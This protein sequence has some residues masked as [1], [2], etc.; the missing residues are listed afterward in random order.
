MLFEVLESFNNKNFS[1][2][3][4]SI[5]LKGASKSTQKSNKISHKAALFTVYLS[6]FVLILLI[7][8]LVIDTKTLSIISSL[9][10][11]QSQILAPAR[12]EKKS[13]KPKI[14]TS[15]EIQKVPQ[16]TFNY[17]GSTTWAS[18]RKI[19]HP[20]ISK[21]Y[22]EFNLRHVLPIN[23]TPGSGAGI[24]MLLEGELDFSQSS[25][26]IKLAEHVL[27][28][29][30][31]FILREYHVAID[32]IVIAVHP[33]LR[34]SGLTIEQLKKIYLGQLTNW[35]EVNGPDLEIVPFSR[36]EEDGGTPEFFRHFVLN[37]QSFGSNVKQVY[38]TT[39]GLRQVVDTP[40]GIYYASAPQIVPQCTVKVLPIAKS[41]EEFISP[42]VLPTVASEN[43]PKQ[44]NQLN[45][46]VIKNATYP[47]TR[48]LSVIVKEDGGLA[49]QAGEAYARLLMTK[50][51]QRLIEEAEFVF[52][53]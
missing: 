6:F 39:D 1:A 36:R 47:I 34:V 14:I 49:Q 7:I 43:C 50:E 3:Q 17:G 15:K 32:A 35:K 46:E 11:L 31:G 16:G 8:T 26:P 20:Q 18:I 2:S 41:G 9:K 28:H 29:E 4:G 37:D 52:I 53:K 23:T 51:M 21:A 45:I 12:N 10:L 33:S 38:S 25:R 40:G 22:P 19:T 13:T 48:Y 44:R 30:L 5:E 24:R 42:Y 27:A